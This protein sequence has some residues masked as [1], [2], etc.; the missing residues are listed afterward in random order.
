M[1]SLQP[2][3]GFR[4]YT[5]L[6]QLSRRNLFYNG[7]RLTHSPFFTS[8]FGHRTEKPVGLYSQDKERWDVVD[9]LWFNSLEHVDAVFHEQNSL[10]QRLIEDAAPFVRHTAVM[11]AEEFMVTPDPIEFPRIANLF[12]LRRPSQMSRQ[13]MLNYWGAQQISLQGTLK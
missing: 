9:Q 11:V 7:I 5:Q 3:L 2:Q 8:F 4:Q 1:L 6:H 10:V 12:C 13:A